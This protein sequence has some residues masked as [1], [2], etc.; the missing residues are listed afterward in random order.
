MALKEMYQS[1]K[2]HAGKIIAGGF[3]LGLSAI[4]L[5]S[6]LNTKKGSFIDTQTGQRYEYN[7]IN[8][9]DSRHL[10]VWPENSPALFASKIRDFDADGNIDHIGTFTYPKQPFEFN[11]LKTRPAYRDRAQRLYDLALADSQ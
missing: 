11:V 2:K 10:Y 7:L 6:I 3:L 8:R 9:G 1:A 5:D 4:S